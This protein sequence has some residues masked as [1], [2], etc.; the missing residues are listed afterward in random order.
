[1]CGQRP[2]RGPCPRARRWCSRRRA[3]SW[4]VPLRPTSAAAKREC[5]C[6][7][8]ERG[9]PS[10][11]SVL[12]ANGGVTVRQS[13]QDQA[14]GNGAG[15]KGLAELGP[16]WISAIA[17]FILAVIGVV[18]LLITDDAGNESESSEPSSSQ[19]S[20]HLTRLPEGGA[21][22]ESTP[23]GS[24]FVTSPDGRYEAVRTPDNNNLLVRSTGTG[25]A[26]FT[27]H[28]QRPE[29]SNDFKAGDLLP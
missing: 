17:A 13:K 20:P 6:E 9:L 4:F 14:G 25:Q 19:V 5:D 8:L 21:T 15:R 2:V 28:P 12:L 26:V 27:T 23:P 1:M 16:A 11:R 10:G 18:G 24:V 29:Q 7:D 22:S 3:R